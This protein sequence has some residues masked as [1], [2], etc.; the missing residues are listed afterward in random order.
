VV[1][2]ILLY[3]ERDRNGMKQSTTLILAKERKEEMLAELKTYFLK[4]RG[5]E[6]GD[7]GSTLILDVICEKLAPEF[8]NQGVRDSC[9]SMKDGINPEII[10]FFVSLS[11]LPG[12]PPPIVF[13]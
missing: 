10:A 3:N 9:H 7:R 2:G 5:E 6:I 11:P 4:E 12:G 13:W 8:Y 1:T